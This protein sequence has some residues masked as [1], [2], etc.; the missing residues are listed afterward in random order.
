MR[1]GVTRVPLER[2][3]FKSTQQDRSGLSPFSNPHKLFFQMQDSLVHISRLRAHSSRNTKRSGVITISST[4]SFGSLCSY[5]SPTLSPTCC[6]D[7]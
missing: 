5:S 4:R 7:E 3:N 2:K 6:S 1:L